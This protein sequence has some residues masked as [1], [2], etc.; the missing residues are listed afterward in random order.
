MGNESCDMDS[1]VSAL[2]LA[3]LLTKTLHKCCDANAKVIPIVNVIEDEFSL[4]TESNYVLN[5]IGI[6]THLLLFK[7]VIHLI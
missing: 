1:M 3:Y 5:K 4:R 2:A 6:H 7:Y